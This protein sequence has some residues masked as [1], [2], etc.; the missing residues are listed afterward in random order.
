MEAAL[1][2][3]P[4]HWVQLTDET[5]VPGTSMEDMPSDYVMTY[6]PK[7][8]QVH[9]NPLGENV[10]IAVPEPASA[11]REGSTADATVCTPVR[12]TD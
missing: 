4:K 8:D 9:I 1:T 11:N 12:R 3:H 5:F 10:D 2:V 6:S 7:S